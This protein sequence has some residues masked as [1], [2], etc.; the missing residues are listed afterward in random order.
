M[1]KSSVA[2]SNLRGF[3]IVMVVAFHSFIAYLGSQPASPLPFDNPPFGWTVNPIVDSERWFGFDLFCA[4]QY[5]YLMHLMFFLS[6]LFVW[7]SLL[8]KGGRAFLQ[9]RF[10]R[11][12]VPFLLGAYLLMPLAYYPVYR[13]TA[14]DPSVSAFWS[15]WLALPFW[16]S[17]PMW[18]LWCLLA[19]NIVAAG[20]YC[21]APRVGQLL[22]RLSANA[23]SSPGRFFI[24]LVSASALAYLPLAAF[25]E[26]WQWVEFGPFAFQPSFAPQYAIYFFAALGIGAYGLEQG[27]FAADGMLAR[28]WHLWLVGAPAAFL[29]WIIP[30]ALI[31]QGAVNPAGPANRG[32]P[33]LR[34][35]LG[36][37]LLR[38]GSGVPALRCRDPADVRQP[39]GECLWHL[40]RPLRVRDL[41]A[42]PPA[43]SRIVRHGK[44]S[45]RVHR[46]PPPELGH[47]RCHVP[48]VH[49]RSPDGRKAAPIGDRVLTC[50][51]ENGGEDSAA[52]TDQTH[53]NGRQLM[54]RGR[55]WKSARIRSPDRCKRAILS[56]SPSAK[57]LPPCFTT[58]PAIMTVSTLAVPACITTQPTTSCIGTMLMSS[59]R[60]RTMSACLPGVIEPIR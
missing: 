19:L 40:S 58:R 51:R 53:R 12:G 4:F 38:C 9:D 5:V 29:L 31:V 17:G 34:A 45:D 43:R 24:G 26:P 54:R 15:H 27:L 59:V 44:G 7:P 37:E 10:L 1:S 50:E 60:S 16:P 55:A 6:G 11:L 47:C 22:A 21:L 57:S 13:V 49:R 28:H 39:L 23:G 48:H 46:Y 25:F 35:V 8:R 33:W 14:V 18:F 41:A 42:I 36:D 56:D 32:R 30:T 2:L 52:R 3:A 20:L